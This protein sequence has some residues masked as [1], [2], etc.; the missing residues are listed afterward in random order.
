[1]LT[2]H[3]AR[4]T[5]IEAIEAGGPDVA[6]RDDYDID[7]I[8]SEIHDAVGGYDMEKLEPTD[9]WAIVERHAKPTAGPRAAFEAVTLDP[10]HSM[11]AVRLK[12]GGEILWFEEMRVS[13]DAQGYTDDP[14]EP[15]TPPSADDLTWFLRGCG[16][17]VVGTWEG[18][19][20]SLW[21]S[22]R[23]TEQGGPEVTLPAAVLAKI[24]AR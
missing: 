12:F 7:A 20:S 19:G 21:A 14:Y 13:F 15:S 17:H 24:A 6:T 22:I 11:I 3:D 8:V 23:P 4:N 1:M 5:V 16:W 9:F 10:E 2:N 18:S